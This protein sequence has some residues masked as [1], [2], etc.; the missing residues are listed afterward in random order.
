MMYLCMDKS[1][2]RIE[3]SRAILHSV[4]FSDWPLSDITFCNTNV[5]AVAGSAGDRANPLHNF[6]PSSTLI[7]RHRT[8]RP[9]IPFGGVVD[10]I[11]TVVD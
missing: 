4:L 9:L 8:T 3:S 10:R 7:H 2:S 5:L 6:V 11:H 1:T